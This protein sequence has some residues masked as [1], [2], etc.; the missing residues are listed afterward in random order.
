MLVR[1][2]QRSAATSRTKQI[3][4]RDLP[5]SMAASASRAFNFVHGAPRHRPTP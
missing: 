4:N 5:C 2:K 1:V 3:A